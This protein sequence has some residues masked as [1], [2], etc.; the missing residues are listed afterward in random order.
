LRQTQNTTQGS[1]YHNANTTMDSFVNETADASANLA[2][3]PAIIRNEIIKQCNL[4]PLVH[5]DYIYMEIWKGMYGLPQ[6]GILV[7]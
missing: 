4:L 7:N 3:T 2:M 5:H 1:G 6:A